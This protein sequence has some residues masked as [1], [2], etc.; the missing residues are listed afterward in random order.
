MAMTKTRLT[1]EELEHRTLPATWGLPWP[2]STHLKVSFVPDGTLVNGAPSTLF[3]SLNAQ[4]NTA[5]WQTEVLRAIQTWASKANINVGLVTD[6]GQKLGVAGAIEGDARFGDIRISARPMG[7]NNIAIGAPYDPVAGTLSGDIVLNS[8]DTFSIGYQGPAQYDLYSVILHEVGHSLGI[9]DNYDNTSIMYQSYQGL[10]GGLSSADTAALQAIHGTRQP[11]PFESFTGN[12][13]FDT[14]GAVAVLNVEGNINTLTEND[15]YRFTLPSYA[16]GAATVQVRAAGL[17]LFVPKITVFDAARNAVAVGVA[18]GPLDNTVTL[19]LPDST[20]GTTYYFK[21]ESS[22]ADVFGIGMYRLKLNVGA[23]SAA[24]IQ[25]LDALYDGSATRTIVNTTNNGSLNTALPL[26]QGA[27]SRFAYTISSVTSGAGDVDF[28]RVVAPAS[29]TPVLVASV[30]SIDAQGLEP[31]L[32]VFD[33]SGATVPVKIFANSDGD[34]L[35]QATDIQPGATYYLSV[36]ADQSAPEGHSQ[37]AY[38]LG[39]NFPSTPLA[40]KKLA[41]ND[42]SSTTAGAIAN[43]YTMEISHA[44]LTHF[45]LSLNAPD[46]TVVVAARLRV[47]DADGNVVLTLDARAGKKN[48]MAITLP[49]GTYT[50]RLVAATQNNSPLPLTKYLLRGK[51]LTD[52]IDGNPIDPNNP[53]PPPDPV[54]NPGGNPPSDPNSN[55]WTPPP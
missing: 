55:P 37:G 17:S 3:Q 48:S 9:A 20:P 54:I 13:S 19:T 50:M 45:I 27:D 24:Q 14:A 32:K 25:A 34:Y 47:F 31:I 51:S 8:L 53:P 18:A 30:A 16:T 46:A 35:I 12:G 28:Y 2:D 33:S 36:R 41:E 52:P 7:S 1:L 39:V 5:Q 43:V 6:G 22:T 40:I 29:G 11:D 10:P 15:Y 44:Q 26:V 49:E 4:V 23:D 38:I 42:V 21:V